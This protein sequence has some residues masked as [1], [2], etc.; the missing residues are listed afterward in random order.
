MAIEEALISLLA[1]VAGDRNH[2][3]RAEGIS[4][5]DGAYTRLSWISSVTDYHL[6]GPSGYIRRRLQIDAFGATYSAARA[7][8]DAVRGVLSGHRGTTGGTRIMGIMVDGER[9]LNEADAGEV[10]HLFRR[11]ADY[12]IHYSE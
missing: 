7:A 6:A 8:S 5:A 1:G 3:G 11:S 10:N 12:I 2:W 9:D 4:P